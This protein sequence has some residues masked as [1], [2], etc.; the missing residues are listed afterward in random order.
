MSHR[1]ENNCRDMAEKAFQEGRPFQWITHTDYGTGSRPYAIDGEEVKITGHLLPFPVFI[2][3]W[4]RYGPG[5]IGNEP[6]GN[7]RKMVAS[8]K[9]DDGDV[10]KMV[11]SGDWVFSPW[12]SY[13]DRYLKVE[14]VE[15]N[16]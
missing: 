2:I 4:I 3:T 7:I 9:L 8:R 12:G 11:A 13:E 5:H 14:K 6:S 1:P 15:I 10:L 16:P